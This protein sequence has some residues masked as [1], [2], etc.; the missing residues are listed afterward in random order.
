M[1]NFLCGLSAH[2]QRCL[3]IARRTANALLISSCEPLLDALAIVNG[4]I[5]RSRRLRR[6]TGDSEWSWSKEFDHFLLIFLPADWELRQISTLP[7]DI[8]SAVMLHQDFRIMS[9]HH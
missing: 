8:E 2:Q 7:K 5:H 9:R 6:V 4:G 1:V 3:I